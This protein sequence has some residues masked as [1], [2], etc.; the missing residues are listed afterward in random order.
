MKKQQH[1]TSSITT[2]PAAPPIKMISSLDCILSRLNIDFEV[3]VVIPSDSVISLHPGSLKDSTVNGQ[4][5][6][7]WRSTA[8]IDTEGLVD[9]QEEMYS[10]KFGIV[11]SKL[12]RYV[13]ALLEDSWKH[14]NAPPV[15]WFVERPQ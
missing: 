3:S 10:V 13:T 15:K 12:V 2:T 7:T 6:S 4:E 8:L 1:R 5:L 11:S 9:I 14:R